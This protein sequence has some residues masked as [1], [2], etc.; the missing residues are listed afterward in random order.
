MVKLEQSGLS[1]QGR[2]MKRFAWLNLNPCNSFVSSLRFRL[3]YRIIRYKK[4]NRKV[5]QDCCVEAEVRLRLVS[6]VNAS[7]FSLPHCT[8]VRVP[9]RA[10]G[11]VVPL[12][13][14][15]NPSFLFYESTPLSPVHH[16][17][18][19]LLRSTS[20]VRIVIIL[21]RSVSYII[22]PYLVYRVY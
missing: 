21:P 6:A 3:Q 18:S 16:H 4:R 17:L 10:H 7:L 11:Q 1:G 15:F 12:L 22:V 5:I 13:L 8:L 2:R 20:A 19:P 14:F 9:F